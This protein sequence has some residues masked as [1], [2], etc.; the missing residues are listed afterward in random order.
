MLLI[1]GVQ[2]HH[3]KCEMKSPQLVDLSWNSID[4]RRNVVKFWPILA[5]ILRPEKVAERARNSFEINSKTIYVMQSGTWKQNG[6]MHAGI[7]EPFMLCNSHGILKM[8]PK[9]LYVMQCN[10]DVNEWL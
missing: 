8:N 3:L 10:H 4:F 7:W 1:W 9:R 2:S 5:E 6:A